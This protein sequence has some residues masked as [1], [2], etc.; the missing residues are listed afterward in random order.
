MLLE[1]WPEIVLCH[2]VE[3]MYYHTEIKTQKKY[4]KATSVDFITIHF[5][6]IIFNI[7]LRW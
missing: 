5:M 7:I 3:L 4:I 1:I 2:F 6:S